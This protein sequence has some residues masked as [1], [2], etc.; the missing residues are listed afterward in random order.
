[1]EN[2]QLTFQIRQKTLPNDHPYLIKDFRHIA[3][4]YN[5]KNEL[6]TL[7]QFGLKKIQDAQRMPTI[8]RTYIA[9]PLMTMGNVVKDKLCKT[10]LEFYEN[11]RTYLG[12][13]KVIDYRTTAKCLE[14]ICRLYGVCGRFEAAK[15][16]RQVWS[17]EHIDPARVYCTI[18]L[19]YRGAKQTSKALEYFERSEVIYQ[20]NYGHD[21]SK[22]KNIQNYIAQLNNQQTISMTVSDIQSTIDEPTSIPNADVV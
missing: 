7:R 18:A 16:Y 19:S 5:K 8:N 21:H 10:A 12:E 9:Q 22:V 3:F 2:Y 15:F 17:I 1:M 13:S 4:A 20:T 14:D 11:A 6:E